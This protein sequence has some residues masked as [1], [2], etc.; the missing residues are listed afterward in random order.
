MLTSIKELFKIGP[1]P[2]SSHTIGPYNAALD[3]KQSIENSA[4][5][6]KAI[7][8]GSLALTGRGHRTDYVIKTVLGKDTKIDFDINT[9]T[10]HPNTMKLIAYNN[11]KVIKEETYVSIGGGTIKKIDEK[12]PQE[13]YT[14]P[15]NSFTEIR[16]AF[17]KSKK[18]KIYDFVKEY[19]GSDLKDFLV[20]IFNKM[21]EVIKAG[22]EK[23]GFVAGELKVKRI[24]KELYEEASKCC[25]YSEKRELY[26]SA[27]AYA[28][29]ESN[30]D[31]SIVVT[32]PTCGAAGVLPAVLYYYYN[33]LS[34]SMDDIINALCIAGL[35][36]IT[37][38]QNATISGAVGGCQAEIGT[39][40]SMAAAAICVLNKLDFSYIEY[41]AEVGMEHQLG[42]TCD[43]VLGYVAIPCIERNA[44]SALKAYDS[45]MFAKYL[46]PHRKN[47]VTLDEVIQAMKETGNDLIKDYKETSLGGLAKSHKIHRL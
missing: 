35:I 36:G 47:A 15:F 6:F 33:N 38:K 40:T 18:N 43:P 2:S 28:V 42:L 26:I 34:A 11:D 9:T 4:T 19:E 17:E 31:N 30:A 45:Y 32:A 1:G 37:V 20:D 8:Y 22:L 12:D 14:Y 27:Y 29:S 41:A 3:F 39:A 5:S 46:I 10:E 21:Q 44:Y 16:Q 24:A 7:L 23:E 13:Q 25:D